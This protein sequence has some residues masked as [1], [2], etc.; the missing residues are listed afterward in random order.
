MFLE[1]LERTER[2]RSVVSVHDVDLSRTVASE[3]VFEQFCSLFV[4]DCIAVVGDLPCDVEKFVSQTAGEP[5]VFEILF[6]NWRM[7]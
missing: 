4:G 1:I 6:Q 3:Y 5:S 7:V 2:S